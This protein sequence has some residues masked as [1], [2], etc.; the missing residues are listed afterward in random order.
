MV[1]NIEYKCIYILYIYNTLLVVYNIHIK[2]T[3]HFGPVL[4][5]TTQ[6]T[7][8]HLPP[9]LARASVK[10]PSLP[11]GGLGLGGTWRFFLGVFGVFFLLSQE[12]LKVF[13]GL[14]F[15]GFHH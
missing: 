8:S 10:F 4:F 13:E 14:I 12:L 2:Y 11:R 15:V 9:R 5:H 6:K 3:H 1:I 7:S